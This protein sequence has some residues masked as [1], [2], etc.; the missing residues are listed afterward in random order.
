[1]AVSDE[2]FN[3]R[4]RIVKKFVEEE[5]V[6]IGVDMKWFG[7]TYLPAFHQWEEKYKAY[8]NPSFRTHPIVFAKKEAREKLQPIYSQLVVMLKGNSK[9]TEPQLV[10]LKIAVNKGG[11]GR[12]LPPPDQPPFLRVDTSVAGRITIFVYNVE[13]MK[14]G[15][16]RGAK[17]CMLSYGIVDDDP[18][19]QEMLT[20]YVYVTNGKVVIDFP[21][22]KRGKKLRV[23]GRW[24]NAAGK[25][26]PWSDIITVYIP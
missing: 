14:R 10:N 23:A 22:P 12:A 1:M 13:G 6:A 26:S 8:R 20:E 11:G 21:W 24:M 17:C 19:T 2:E 9:L 25:F 7:D 15:R 3:R 18:I 16:P 4:V 5:G